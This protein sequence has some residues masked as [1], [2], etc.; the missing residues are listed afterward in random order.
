M[1][2]YNGNP[3]DNRAGPIPPMASDPIANKQGYAPQPVPS[4]TGMYAP[5]AMR[6]PLS[7]N[8]TL[9][10]SWTPDSPTRRP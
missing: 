1:T 6:P 9:K 8:D 2:R 5:A 10:P 4:E 3:D 7:A